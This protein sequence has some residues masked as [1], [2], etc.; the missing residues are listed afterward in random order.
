MLPQETGPDGNDLSISE[1]SLSDRP[2][3][4]EKPFSLLASGVQG[5]LHIHQDDQEV[6]DQS[7][8]G[9]AGRTDG[10]AARE[11]KLQGDIFVLRK[12][13]ASFALFNDALQDTNLA[14]QV[15]VAL[16]ISQVLS[17]ERECFLACR[18]TIGTTDLC[19][20]PQLDRIRPG[21]HLEEV[22][23]LRSV[24]EATGYY[25]LV[26]ANATIES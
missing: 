18:L 25:H 9:L 11:E 13:N 7:I 16:F 10:S 4:L 1:L 20:L 12:L 23:S 17:E 5:H 2:R 19:L 14:N 21:V 24:A 3:T 22:G 26:L 15:A 8:P 6:E